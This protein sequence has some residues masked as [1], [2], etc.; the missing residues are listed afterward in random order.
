MSREL[1]SIGSGTIQV[2]DAGATAVLHVTGTTKDG[3][4]IDL[5]INCPTVSR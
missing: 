4:G 2:E 1:A 3:V 5:K